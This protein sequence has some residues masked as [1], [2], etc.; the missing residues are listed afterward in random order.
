[1]AVLFVMEKNLEH[2]V[3]CKVTMLP[4]PEQVS[5]IEAHSSLQKR[6]SRYAQSVVLIFPF[7]GGALVV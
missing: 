7:A 3:S 4:K 2:F 1:M 6:A 5:H